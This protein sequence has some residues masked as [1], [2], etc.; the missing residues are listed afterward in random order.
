M[1]AW[2]AEENPAGWKTKGKCKFTGDVMCPLHVGSTSSDD[3]RRRTGEQAR[4]QLDKG[5][6]TQTERDKQMGNWYK[7]MDS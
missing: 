6:Q 7:Q 4:R 5:R 1:C 2:E 3:K